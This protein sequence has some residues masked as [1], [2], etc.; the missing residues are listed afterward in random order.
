MKK[1]LKETHTN[2]KIRTYYCSIKLE[3]FIL[4]IEIFFQFFP[5]EHF[6]LIAFFS[7]NVSY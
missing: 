3:Q 4:A 1:Y 5:G 7:E 2:N 6:K